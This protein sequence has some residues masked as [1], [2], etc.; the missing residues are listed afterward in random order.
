MYHKE[1][2]YPFF[3]GKWRIHCS[4]SV[5]VLDHCSGLYIIFQLIIGVD[6]QVK[7]ISFGFQSRKQKPKFSEKIPIISNNTN[8]IFLIIVIVVESTHKIYTPNYIQNCYKCKFLST[9]FN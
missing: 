2:S 8:D 9:K 3:C 5:K 4:L 6:S 1:V 7:G